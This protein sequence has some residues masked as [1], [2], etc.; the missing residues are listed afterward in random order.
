MWTRPE[1]NVTVS[2][3][4]TENRIRAYGVRMP[5]VDALQAVYDFGTTR[6]YEA[7]RSGEDL[8]LPV[9]KAGRRY[10]TPTAA[11][12]RLLHLDE[13]DSGAA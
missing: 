10:I 6:A 9:L 4:W 8:G 13:A 1:R 7:L 3:T 2:N 12:L 11:V 5:S